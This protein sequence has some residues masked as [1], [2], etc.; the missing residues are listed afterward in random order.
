[1][2]L[3]T[4]KAAVGVESLNRAIRGLKNNLPL[5]KIALI[6][7]QILVDQSPVDTGLLRANWFVTAKSDDPH[8][9]PAKSHTPTKE[10]NITGVNTLYITNNINYV[11]HANMRSFRPNFIES[12]LSLLENYIRVTNFDEFDG[13][14]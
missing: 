3:I 8:T 7:E 10:T 13:G 2:A 9:T 4:I 5:A 14:V 11:L 12:S 6:G 1:M